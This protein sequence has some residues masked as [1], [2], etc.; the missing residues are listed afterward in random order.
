MDW[1]DDELF[2]IAHTIPP[3]PSGH[4]PRRS[5][6]LRTSPFSPRR[7]FTVN[8]F[9]GTWGAME[10]MNGDLF[11]TLYYKNKD[12]VNERRRQKRADR[13]S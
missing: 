9:V 10:W 12:E 2:M 6:C 1:I 4:N 3:P 11:P 5:C 13:T 7:T 8:H